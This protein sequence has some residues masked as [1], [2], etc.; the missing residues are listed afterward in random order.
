MDDVLQHTRA[1]VGGRAPLQ[2]GYAL[3]RA[4]AQSAVE[5]ACR[6]RDELVQACRGHPRIDKC[7]GGRL[8][9]AERLW[10]NPWFDAESGHLFSFTACP[11]A[12]ARNPLKRVGPPDA[13]KDSSNANGSGTKRPKT[14]RW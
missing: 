3:A 8:E 10:R 1:P 9:L 14:A 6:D 7:G 13:D 12:G 4:R 5:L 11:A 2:T